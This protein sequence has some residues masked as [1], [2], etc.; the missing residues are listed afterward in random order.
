[1]GY[2]EHSNKTLEGKWGDHRALSCKHALVVSEIK[3]TDLSCHG[4]L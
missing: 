4:P 3:Y 1:V 2:Q